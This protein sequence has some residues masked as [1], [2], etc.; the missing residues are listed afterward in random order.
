MSTPHT[1]LF[2]LNLL[3][4]ILGS[5]FLSWYYLVDGK[6]LNRPIEFINGVD[7]LNFQLEK[8][9][10]SV[11]DTPEMLTSFCKT[12]PSKGTVEWTLIDGQRVLYGESEPRSIPEGCYPETG[13]FVKAPIQRIP[14]YI[15]NTCD[16]YFVGV[17][18]VT[19][20]GDRVVEYKY[21][22][23]KFCIEGA[24]LLEQITK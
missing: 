8:D 9:V 6:I 19:I 1:K 20:S 18:K 24:D 5:I 17:G 14:V 22:T 12:R 13:D 3:V 7:P 23:E 10:Y 15:E 16:A 4:I 21:K 2:Y 11:G